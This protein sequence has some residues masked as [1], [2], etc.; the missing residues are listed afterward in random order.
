MV[1]LL[2]KKTS[3]ELLNKKIIEAKVIEKGILDYIL[4]LKLDNGQ[5]ILIHC[6]DPS[7]LDASILEPGELHWSEKK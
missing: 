2:T 5:R 3:R 7:T 1:K 6:D 4:K